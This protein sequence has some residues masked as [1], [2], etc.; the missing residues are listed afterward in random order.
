L[1]KIDLKAVANKA[2]KGSGNVS[3]SSI[4]ISSINAIAQKR[5]D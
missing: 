5:K 4:G 1:S 3:S 2:L